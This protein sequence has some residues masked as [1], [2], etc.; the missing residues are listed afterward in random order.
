MSSCEKI[1]LRSPLVLKE[2]LVGTSGTRT[3]EKKKREKGK[4]AGLSF[5]S[6]TLCTRCIN[7]FLPFLSHK[8]YFP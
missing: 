7:L 1:L 3:N 4:K 5:A 8:Y 6:L 2:T